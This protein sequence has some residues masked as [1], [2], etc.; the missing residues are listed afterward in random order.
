MTHYDNERPSML[1]IIGDSDS[2][3]DVDDKFQENRIQYHEM[4]KYLDSLLRLSSF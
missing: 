2:N 4:K 1:I 3:M